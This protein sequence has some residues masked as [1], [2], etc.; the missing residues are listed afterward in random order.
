MKTTF[1]ELDR[2][3]FLQDVFDYEHGSDWK[4]QGQLPCLIDFH[5]ESCPPCQALEPELRKTA[6]ACGDQVLFYRVDFERESQLASELGIKN[7]PT[8]VLCPL[9]RKPLVMQGATN[10]ERLMQIIEREL[11]LEGNRNDD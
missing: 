7:L 5:D 1:R 2:A 10:K 9:D 4:Y 8:L 6:E 11:N 3:G